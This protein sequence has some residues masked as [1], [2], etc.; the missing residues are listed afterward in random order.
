MNSAIK[1]GKYAKKMEQSNDKYWRN[2]KE[3][4]KTRQ[5]RQVQSKA[6]EKMKQSNDKYQKKYDNTKKMHARKTAKKREIAKKLHAFGNNRKLT[7]ALKKR[8]QSKQKRKVDSYIQKRELYGPQREV[9]GA[10]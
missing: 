10:L 4:E 8:G 3:P 2:L 6:R 1:P 5:I 7:I 9:V